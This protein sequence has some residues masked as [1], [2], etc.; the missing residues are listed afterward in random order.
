MCSFALVALVPIS[1]LGFDLPYYVQVFVAIGCMWGALCT[2]VGSKVLH[3]RFG[4][5]VTVNSETQTVVIHRDD[6]NVTIPA[7]SVIGLQIL[8][9]PKETG[10][11]QLNLAFRDDTGEIVRESLTTNA[12]QHYVMRLAKKY[13]RFAGWPLLEVTETQITN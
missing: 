13:Q 10:G 11:Y 5:T 1:F 3:N 4:T 6:F 2:I 8:R 7:S 9:G 12:I